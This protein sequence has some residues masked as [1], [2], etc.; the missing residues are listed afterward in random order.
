MLQN[1]SDGELIKLY[2][3]EHSERAFKV[4]VER[5]YT[6]T[7]QRFLRHCHHAGD[8]DDLTQQLWMRV[9]DNLESYRDDDRFPSF[10]NRISTNLLTDYWR[11]KGRRDR[12]FPEPAQKDEYDSVSRAKAANSNTESDCEVRQQIDHLT[13]I[14]IPALP[15]EQRLVFLLRHESEYWEGKQRLEWSH[16]AELNGIDEQTAW[17]RFETARNALLSCLND[18]QSSSPNLDEE[19]LLIFLVWTQSQRLSKQQEF[20]WDYFSGLLN[21]STNTLK[22]RYRA[23]LKKLSEG[24]SCHG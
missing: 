1:L 3:H 21:V 6:R 14:L 17:S 5:H 13:K 22:T 4:L 8:A 24:L 11:R 12:V 7:R 20:T 9:V 23:A 15:C 19:S 18:D 16:M 10:L 2:L